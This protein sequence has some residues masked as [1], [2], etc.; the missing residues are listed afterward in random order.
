MSQHVRRTLVTLGLM[1]ALL[2]AAP[3]PSRAAGLWEALAM[4]GLT[5]RIAA[6]LESLAPEAPRKKAIQSPTDLPSATSSDQGSAIDPNGVH[7]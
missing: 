6:W 7:K 4:P 5:A 3:A 2:F 1:A